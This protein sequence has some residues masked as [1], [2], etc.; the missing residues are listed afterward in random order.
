MIDDK[1][2]QEAIEKAKTAA[3]ANE[4]YK[5]QIFTAVLI[6]ELLSDGAGRDSVA[7]QTVKQKG[8]SLQEL[9]KEKK[10]T[11]EVQKTLLFGYYLETT[12]G[13]TEFAAKD[14]DECY[15]KAKEKL[16]PNLSDKIKMN[17]QNGFMMQIGK[18]ESAITYALTNTGLKIIDAGFE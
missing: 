6:K 7:E 12:M 11:N 17:V 15:R 1:K 5:D 13:R 14:I 9:L 2:L 10:P 3:S 8:L 16:P 4:E 18:T